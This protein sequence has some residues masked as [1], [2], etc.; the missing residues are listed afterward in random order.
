MKV[1]DV[2]HTGVC[3]VDADTPVKAIARRMRDEDIGAVPVKADGKIVGLITD[4]DIALRGVA[5]DEDLAKIKARDVMTPHLVA[6]SPGDDI[7]EA[8]DLMESNQVRRLPVLDADKRPVGILSLGD[9]CSRLPAK[10]AG[11][12]LRSVAAHHA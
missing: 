2:M 5:G 7:D 12:V 9:L 10:T 4:R 3:V 11:A 1:K 6:C 8:L